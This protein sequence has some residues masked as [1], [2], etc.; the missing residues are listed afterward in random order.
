MSVDMSKKSDDEQLTRKALREATSRRGKDAVDAGVRAEQSG[1][2][3]RVLRSRD[4][5]SKPPAPELVDRSG[6]RV[7]HVA[8]A[9]ELRRSAGRRGS[10]GRGRE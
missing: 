6:M 2:V 3:R 7:R 9:R 5:A 1:R 4:L 10:A 8:S